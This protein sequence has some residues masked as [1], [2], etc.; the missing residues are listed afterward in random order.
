[1]YAASNPDIS[2]GTTWFNLAVKDST[3]VQGETKRSLSGAIPSPG[4]PLVCEISLKTAEGDSLVLEVWRLAVVAGGCA[5]PTPPPPTLGERKVF[6]VFPA[7]PSF[8][9]LFLDFARSSCFSAHSLCLPGG[10]WPMRAS[11]TVV[12]WPQERTREG[13]NRERTR[14]QGGRVDGWMVGK[15][16]ESFPSL[17]LSLAAALFAL[18]F[19][20]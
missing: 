5:Q 10:R 13:G 4:L 11:P 2:L 7:A 20:P 15:K 1:M 9:L 19:L 6:S 8:P 14:Q 16:E 3:E 17:C 18:S 12:V